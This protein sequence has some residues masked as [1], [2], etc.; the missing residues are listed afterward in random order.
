MP[1][2]W[3]S[4]A[5]ARLQPMVPTI[6]PEGASDSDKY[7]HGLKPQV[8]G[9]GGQNRVAKTS[10]SVLRAIRLKRRLQTS[11]N[12]GGISRGGAADDRARLVS[13][14]LRL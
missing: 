13:F 4:S 2:R 5:L 14:T 10:G 11:Q 8:D 1:R 7:R 6:S 3:P 9:F 12:A